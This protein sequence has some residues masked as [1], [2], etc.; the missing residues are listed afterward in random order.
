MVRLTGDTVRRVSIFRDTGDII[1]M[2]GWGTSDQPLFV[3]FFPGREGGPAAR[4]EYDALLRYHDRMRGNNAC[5][6]QKPIGIFRDE[7]FGSALLFEWTTARRGDRYFKLF[8]PFAFLRRRGIAA[9][10]VWLSTFHQ[11]G[12]LSY[13]P[14]RNCLDGDRLIK[15]LEG[16]AELAPSEKPLSHAALQD[17]AQLVERNGS[18]PVTSAK[19]HADFLPMNVFITRKEVIGFDFT[20]NQTGPVL[21]DIARFL[22]TLVWYGSFDPMRNRGEKFLADVRVFMEA[23][24]RQ[25]GPDSPEIQKI[26]YIR[27]LMDSVHRLHEGAQTASA[28]KRMTKRKHLRIMAQVLSHVLSAS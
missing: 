13:E 7:N 10:A 26:F 28:R 27:A 11:I 14:L 18:T 24:S 23:Y 1:S 6:C 2:K 5:G 17:F 8:V 25:V 4:A 22:T 21:I 9:T 20:A 3:K 19:I 15:D 12:G 16:L